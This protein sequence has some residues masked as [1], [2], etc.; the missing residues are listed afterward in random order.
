M[1]RHPIKASLPRSIDVVLRRGVHDL[2]TFAN[3]PPVV[4]Y[5]PEGRSSISGHCATVFGCSGF[6]GRYV[7]SKLAKSGSNV[8]VP[9][10]DDYKI[11]HLRVSGD[12]GGVVQMEWELRS[13]QQI[14]ECLRHSDIVYNLVGL[15]Y[16]TKNYKWNEVH[17]EGAA[18]I[19][20]IARENNVSRFVQVSHLNASPDSKSQY[21][22]AKYA[23]EKAVLSE[24]PD[25]VIVRPS[26]M[27]GH[28]DRFLNQL[29]Y[30]YRTFKFNGEQTKVRPVH[31]LDVAEILYRIMDM[32]ELPPS[33]I[34]L[35]GPTTYTHE[36]LLDLARR[37]TDNSYSGLA[38]PKSIA[39]LLSRIAQYALWW[40]NMSPDEIE[41]RCL[42]D[43]DV[44]G[45]WDIFGVQPT[46]LDDVAIAY[47]RRFRNATK[48]EY[49]SAVET[50]K[51]KHKRQSYYSEAQ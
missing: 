4:R 41:R 48:I 51:A 42:D 28:E 9:Y 25:A 40:P 1:L 34:N 49:N 50:A 22:K 24:F 32:P 44:P 2:V 3:R 26:A 5:G 17:V 43:V 15:D 12:L 11:R 16:E 36:Q 31:V 33:P 45:D 18:R 7:V 39:L 38:V 19:A 27:Y 20:R 23:G 6:L 46:E 14:A 10:R 35:P 13:E 29:G 30:W 8:V 47:M 21:Y 37:I